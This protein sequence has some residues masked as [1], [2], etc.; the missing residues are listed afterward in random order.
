[1]RIGVFICKCGTNIA[2]TVDTEA[3][4]R[5]ALEYPDVVYATDYMY[6]CSEPGQEEI[7]EAII[8]NRLQGVVVA[9]CTPHMHEPTFRRAVEKAGLNRYMF[10]QANIREHVSWVNKDRESNTIKA[11]D[12]VHMAVEKLRLNQPLFSSK[13]PINKRVLVIGGGIAGIQAAMDCS[14]GGLDVVMVERETTIGGK[15]A[16]LDKTFPTIDCS[17]CILGPKMVDISQK[18]NISLHAYSEI[19][20]VSG[21]IGNFEVKIRKKATYVDWN[22]CTGCG[23]CTQKCPSKKTYDKFNEGLGSTTAIN[24]PFPQAIPK[25]AR[26]NAE[27]CLYL[28][29]GKCKK[30]EKVCPADAIR[31]DMEDEIITEDVG[32]IVV[33]TGYDMF[34]YSVYGEYGGGRYPDVITS[35]QYERILSASGPYGGHIVRPSD[36]KEPRNIVFLSCVGSRDASVGRPYCS[37]VCC[38]Y[39]AKQ[40]IITRDH[41]PDC[42]CYVSYMDIRSPGKNYDEFIRRAQE[43]YGINYIRGRVGKIYPK[44]DRLIVQGVDTLMGVQMDIEADLVVLATGL[45]AS[46]GARELA[47]K[48]RISYDQYGWYMES[49][50]KLRPVETN[51]AGVYLA[52]VCQGPKDIPASVAQ[53]SAAAAKVQIL[54]SRDT[55]ETDPQVALV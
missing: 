3:V 53:G 43:E 35:L 44:D 48:L 29:K 27:S 1:M 24:I 52:G 5:K 11:M 33:A 8:K 23:E 20:S 39:I 49:H 10:E 51:T 7:R 2:N 50:P 22:A 54:F 15:M 31:F 32:A 6:T 13:V 47:E 36:G 21:Y 12:L 40:A 34:D 30:C 17:S 4:A 42:N 37:G 26:I 55:I 19:E 18:E 16:K 28:T 41:L 9:A 46:E 45:E 25:R 38:M 14:D